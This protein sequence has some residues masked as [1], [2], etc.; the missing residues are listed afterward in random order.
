MRR[1][2]KSES[3]RVLSEMGIPIGGVIDIGVL[4]GTPELMNAFRDKKH[5]LVEPVQEHHET[6]HK[7]YSKY[8]IDYELVNCAASDTNGQ[9]NLRVTSVEKGKDITHAHLTTNEGHEKTRVVPVQTVEQI[10]QEHPLPGP[11]YLKIDVDGAEAAILKGAQGM[12]SA[13]SVIEIETGMTSFFERAKLV[14]EAG[15][16]LFDIVDPCY[17]KGRL[18]EVDL[19]FVNKIIAREH[20]VDLSLGSFNVVDLFQGAIDISKWAPYRKGTDTTV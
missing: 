3:L 1:P 9:M 2:L 14:L 10:L 19:I 17:Y 8:G 5:L 4:S 16:E 13:C 18:A 20:G 6:I 7:L 11:Y 15:F 12:L